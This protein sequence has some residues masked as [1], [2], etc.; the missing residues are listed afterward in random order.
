MHSRSLALLGV[1]ALAGCGGTPASAGPEA[2]FHLGV[3]SRKVSAVPE[4]QA[5]FDRGL[6]LSF[7]FNHDAAE[8]AFREAAT[9]DPASP[10]PWWGVAHVN[11]PHINFPLVPP[12]RN[13]KA[14]EAVAKARALLANASPVEKGLVEAQAARF[15]DPPPEKREALDRGYAD[16]MRALWKA[17]PRDADVG[18]LTAEAIMDLRP[19]DYWDA[20]QKPHPETTEVLAILEAVRALDAKHPLAHHL[21][22]HVVEAGPEPARGLSSADLLR[23]LVP[24][25]GHLVHMPAHIYARVGRWNDAALANRKS[26]EADTWFA[27]THPRPGFYAVYMAHSRHFLAWGSMMQG[28]SKLALTT[29]RE[30]VKAIPADFLEA[31]APIADGFMI[32]PSEVM[33]RFGLWTLVLA[34]P[35]PKE[36]FPISRAMWRFTRAVALT[37]LDRLDEAEKER[38]A[39]VA[40]V[41]KVPAEATFG[42]NPGHALLAVAAKA[43]E[44]EMEAKRKRY[45]AAIAALEAGVKLEDALRYDEPPDW[46]QP[47]RHTLG[48]V[49]LVGDRFADAERVYREDLA[50]WPK[51]GWS[52][53][54]ISRALHLQNKHAEAHAADTEFKR[55]W[56]GSD[57]EL[58][59]SCL[60][61]PTR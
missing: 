16:A 46:L 33:M 1:L 24:G 37:A 27:S 39:F 26:I 12:D 42:N 13:A 53:F 31:Y 59:A 48:A 30:M 19:W 23:D 58:T 11:G 3:H 8:T 57:I 29:A 52:L 41:A 36:I 32:F 17:N 18:A 50:R 40:A 5:A 38:E 4:G 49:L 45:D 10:M 56:E 60:C 28:R 22:I 35:E 6:M 61:Q 47:V 54:G 14:L 9:K 51:N 25:A 7:A 43:L 20:A 21:W 34:E 15:Q 2:A 44:G 55:A